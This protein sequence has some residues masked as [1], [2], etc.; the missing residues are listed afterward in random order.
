MSDN[1]IFRQHILDAAD[2]IAGYVADGE[3]FFYKD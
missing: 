1:G 2:D 3:A